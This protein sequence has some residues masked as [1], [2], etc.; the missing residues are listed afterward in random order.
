MIEGLAQGVLRCAYCHGEA[1]GLLEGCCECAILLHADCRRILGR[2]PTIGCQTLSVQSVSIQATPSEPESAPVVPRRSA[3]EATTWALAAARTYFLPVA[4]AAGCLVGG[5]VVVD[6]LFFYSTKTSHSV[7][8]EVAA[9]RDA[10]R[11][12]KINMRRWPATLDDLMRPSSAPNWR[13]PYLDEM[14]DHASGAPYRLVWKG[15]EAWLAIEVEAGEEG[16]ATQLLELLFVRVPAATCGVP[17]T[18]AHVR[19]HQM[20]R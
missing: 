19:A 4:V 13:G 6:A 1:Y 5:A 11:L 20:T 17:P 9:I 12:Y 16:S 18:G 8:H 3:L 10:C 15:Q 2:C 14:P 7:R